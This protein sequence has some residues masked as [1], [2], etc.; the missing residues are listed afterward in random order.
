MPKAA[1]ALSGHVQTFFT[2][3]LVFVIENCP[4]L[5]WAT[6]SDYSSLIG[7]VSSLNQFMWMFYKRCVVQ[8]HP[9]IKPSIALRDWTAEFSIDCPSSDSCCWEL[10]FS[11]YHKISHQNACT[12]ITIWERTLGKGIFFCCEGIEKAH[13]YRSEYT[14]THFQQLQ[15]C[16]RSLTWRCCQWLCAPC[17]IASGSRLS[18]QHTDYTAVGQ[19]TFFSLTFSSFLNHCFAF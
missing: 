8:T 17:T 18:P 11:D 4:R 7:L 2:I 15:L 3:H 16:G 19:Q 13:N 1:A 12:N 5:L 14:H 6:W 9:D 10:Q